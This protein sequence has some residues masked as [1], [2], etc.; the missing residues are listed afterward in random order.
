V[1]KSLIRRLTSRHGIAAVE[2]ATVDEFLAAPDAADASLLFFSGDPARWPEAHD[3]AVVLPEL[4]A[5][6]AGR[7]RAAVVTREAE[8]ELMR[9]F[10]VN[11]LPSLALVRDGETL[12]VIPKIRDW[13]V[14]VARIEAWLAGE[15]PS[16]QRSIETQ[17]ARP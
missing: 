1:T 12:G 9:R 7:L 14:Y 11:V 2:V 16:H 5:A 17:E 4:V 13:S 8:A 15:T 6:F 10:G 3:V